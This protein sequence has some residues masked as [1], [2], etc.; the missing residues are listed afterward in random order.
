MRRGELGGRERVFICLSVSLCLFMSCLS[1][2]SLKSSKADKWQKKIPRCVCCSVS[3]FVYFSPSSL[4]PLLLFLIHLLFLSSSLSRFFSF[5][6]LFCV[7]VFVCFC[8]SVYFFLLLFP[9]LFSLSIFSIF[10]SFLYIL[11]VTPSCPSRRRPELWGITL[12]DKITEV[13]MRQV[14]HSYPFKPSPIP[15]LW[16]SS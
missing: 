14:W 12:R 9:I 4:V 5:S 6:V 16:R 7:I 11:P 3:V 1:H 15:V 8:S 13:F 2:A 10:L